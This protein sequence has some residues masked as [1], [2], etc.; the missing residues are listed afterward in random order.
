MIDKDTITPAKIE[1]VL[2]GRKYSVEGLPWDID[3]KELVDQYKRLLV[4]AGFGPGVLDDEYGRW[5]WIPYDGP[6]K[7]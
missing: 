7:N 2:H 4:V 3:S 1:L 6:E 5:E